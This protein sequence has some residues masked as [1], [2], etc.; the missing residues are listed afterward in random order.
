[1][2]YSFKFSLRY[3]LLITTLL[4]VGVALGWRVISLHV[5]EQDF[6]RHQGEARTVRVV[7]S[8][9]YRGMITDRNGEPL[10]I[11]TPVDSIWLNPKE[12]NSE[13]PQLLTLASLLDLSLD[14]LLE[15]VNRNINR[16]FVYLQRHVPPHLA[17]QVK[18]LEVPGIH[19]KPEYKRYYPAAEVTAHVL[20]FTDID[21]HGQ[22]GL[23]LTFDNWLSGSP[24]SKRVV[25]DRRGR[26]VQILEGIQDMHSGQD[27]VLSLDQRL[28]YLAYRELKKAVLDNGA[29]SGSA[30][31]LDVHTGEILA[32]VNQPSFNPNLRIKLPL[33][34]RFRNRAVTDVMEP[35]S[36]IKTFSVA[37]A[38][39]N[40]KVSPTTKVDTSPG[41]MMVGGHPVREDKQK[42]F[43]E[44]DVATILKKSSNVGVTKLTLALPSESLWQTYRNLGFGVATG[45]HFPGEAS[46]TLVR[47]PKHSSFMLATLAF[48][49]GMNVTP[50]QIAQAYAVLGA[51]GN[52]HPVTFLKQTTKP[53]PEQVLDPVVARQVVDMLAQVVSE[54]SGTKAKV[55]GY[56]M[57]G[58]TGT[59]RKV[60][61]AGGYLEDSHLAVFAGLA[62][63]SQPRFSIVVVI[64]DPKTNSSVYYGSQVAAPVFS[65]IAA[66]AMRIFNIAPDVVDSQNLRVAQFEDGT[67]FHE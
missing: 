55:L 35:G 40:G 45:C 61:P 59:V 30:V 8:A 36:V 23:E 2:K 6:L 43:G 67:S 47:P 58:K 32:M 65:N 53:K 15:K 29:T 52:K 62:P 28:Q 56:Q 25:K 42:N 31:I 41:W 4:C 13:H 63:A 38:L 46:G 39:Q 54:G 9:P 44:I 66:G 5:I 26:E 64:D 12:F 21:D 10:A 50:L 17:L 3:S 27:V 1:M 20:G 49:Y 24:G 37:S 16:E 48:G 34:G 19:L 33:D 57:A 51:G 7:S 11:S 18:A 22:E 14:Q 60:N